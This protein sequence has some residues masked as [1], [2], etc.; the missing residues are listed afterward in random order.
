MIDEG[1]N[2]YLVEDAC[3]AASQ[4]A[5]DAAMRR[6]VQ[7][8]AVSMTTI[9]TVLGFQRDWANKE[10]DDAVMTIFKDCV[11]AYGSGIEYAYSVV[12]KEAQS[13]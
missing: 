1:Y 4:L 8:D 12:H 13:A 10:H 2:V 11:G 9:A 5:H 7:A 3:G 6:C